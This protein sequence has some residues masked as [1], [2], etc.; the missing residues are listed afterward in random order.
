MYFNMPAVREAMHAAPIESEAGL[1]L[2]INPR[3]S[4]SYTYDILSVVPQHQYLI[5]RGEDAALQAIF[6]FQ[7]K[8]PLAEPDQDIAYL[9]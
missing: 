1:F 3:V 7:T 4:T 8:S 5:D 2:T 6:F 9:I